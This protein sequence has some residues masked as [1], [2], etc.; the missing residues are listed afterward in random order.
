MVKKLTEKGMFHF[1]SALDIDCRE[2]EYRQN[3]P[4]HKNTFFGKISR[5]FI[6]ACRLVRQLIDHEQHLT[7]CIL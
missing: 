4:L 7:K 2:E 6:K 3:D 1:T 5:Y